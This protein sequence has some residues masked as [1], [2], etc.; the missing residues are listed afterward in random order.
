MKE[1][2]LLKHDPLR[3][4]EAILSEDFYGKTHKNVLNKSNPV[5]KIK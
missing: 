3:E 1:E 5:S 4:A 2:R